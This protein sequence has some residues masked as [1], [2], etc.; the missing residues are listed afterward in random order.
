MLIVAGLHVPVMPLVDVVGNVGA[1]EFWQIG[2][3][4]VNAGVICGNRAAV[5]EQHCTGIA[6]NI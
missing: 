6:N 1:V 2:P 5:P 3:I 4:A